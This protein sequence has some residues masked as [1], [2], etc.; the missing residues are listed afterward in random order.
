MKVTAIAAAACAMFAGAATADPAETKG[1]LVIKTDDGRFEGKVG[2]RIQF[3][4]NLID[5][6]GGSP[7]TKTKPLTLRL[8]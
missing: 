7:L 5:E 4:G 2:G 6:D 3:D 1:G 8:G